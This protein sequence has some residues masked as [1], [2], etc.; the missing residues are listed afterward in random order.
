MDFEATFDSNRPL[1]G[2]VHL[3]PLPGAPGYCGDRKKLR[4]EALTDAMV[5]LEAGFDGLMVENYGDRPYY[6]DDV[7]DHVVAELTATIR[8][9]GIAVSLPPGVNVLRNDATA[10]LS[11]AAATGGSFVRV[12]VHTGGR[13]TDQGRLEGRAHETLRLRDRLEADVSILADVAVKHSRGVDDRAVDDRTIGAHARETVDRGL[14]DALIVS[15]DETGQPPR[16]D[17]LLSILDGRDDADRDVP[18]LLG[19]G[20]TAENASELLE[21]TDGAIVGTALKRDGRTRNRVDADRAA[22]VVEAVDS[23]R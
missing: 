19:S 10:A 20:V 1:V 8:E 16:T 9:L 11:I 13:D 2:M 22:A 15:G 7:P 6:P 12:N 17:L 18:V 14:A 5:L 4:G 23:V 21:V 3:P